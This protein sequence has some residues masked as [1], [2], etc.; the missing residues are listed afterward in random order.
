MGGEE[1]VIEGACCIKFIFWLLKVRVD[2]HY[3]TMQHNTIQYSMIN[4]NILQHNKL[5]STVQYYAV[6]IHY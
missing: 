6:T 4:N 2:M 1:I 5:V 3:Y